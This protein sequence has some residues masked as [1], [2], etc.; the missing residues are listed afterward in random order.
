MNSPQPRHAKLFKNGNNQAVRIPREFDLPGSDALIYRE[1]DRL[2][3]EAAKPLSLKTLF[4]GWKPLQEG[5]PAIADPAPEPVD[6]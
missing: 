6:L 4:A 1:G 2:I 5:L 3:V